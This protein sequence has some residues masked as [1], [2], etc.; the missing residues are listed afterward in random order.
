VKT[1]SIVERES[2]IIHRDEIEDQVILAL[3][4][5]GVSKDVEIDFGSRLIQMFVGADQTASVG[6]ESITYIPGS[7]RFNAIVA[8]PANSPS[9]ERMRVTGR[10]YTLITI[11]VLTKRMRGHEIIGANDIEMIKV[12]ERAIKGDFIRH[13]DDLVGM[14][15]RRVIQEG[16]AIRRGHIQEPVLV[17]RRSIVTVIHA[18]R[19]M[20]L[21][22]QAR[23]LENGTKGD[24][25]QI[26][27]LDS[28][29]IIEAEVIGAGRVAV[30]P[31][32]RL[33]A[34]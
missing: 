13:P 16:R 29:K 26:A 9:A 23:A 22:T 17:Q 20:R 5:Y 12:R 32:R 24:F 25:I 6:I 11:P 27:N 19:F 14:S 28:K 3:A 34:N 2:Q 33:A 30:R 18:S 21:T 31:P 10:V 8:A 7:G 15:A 1:R 4:Q